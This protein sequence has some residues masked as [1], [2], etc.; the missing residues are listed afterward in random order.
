MSGQNLFLKSSIWSPTLTSWMDF[1]P[2]WKNKYLWCKSTMSVSLLPGTKL[3]SPSQRLAI[4]YKLLRVCFWGIVQ[5]W[6]SF[7]HL[8]Y[9]FC[10]LGQIKKDFP[11][12]PVVRLQVPGAGTLG[13]IPGQG[14]RSHVP[15][16]RVHMPRWKSEDPTCCNWA[17]KISK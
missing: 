4:A 9:I 7:Y 10:R 1:L 5:G 11:G 6:P 8:F 15:Q 14:S 12:D 16:S 2:G 13:S 3:T 17:K